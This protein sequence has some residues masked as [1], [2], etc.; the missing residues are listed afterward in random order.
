M[1]SARSDIEV[2]VGDM[3]AAIS[4]FQTLIQEALTPTADNTTT[5]TAPD[6]TAVTKRTTSSTTE[7]DEINAIFADIQRLADG[8]APL[9]SP[10][11]SEV[12]TRSLARRFSVSDTV[13]ALVDCLGRLLSGTELRKRAV[14]AGSEVDDL[15]T[16]LATIHGWADGTIP[17]PS[18]DV[19][20]SGSFTVDD[21]LEFATL[22]KDVIVAWRAQFEATLP[23]AEETNTTGAAL[24]E[25]APHSQGFGLDNQFYDSALDK[26][27]NLTLKIALKLLAAALDAYADTL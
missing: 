22:L 20:A 1:L 15:A 13:R 26:R 7:L 11:S 21:G 23:A 17:L 12:A 6:T 4:T 24:V 8:S 25:R 2:T 18:E 3:T 16:S 9:P 27:G 10:G 14:S 5:P 19:S